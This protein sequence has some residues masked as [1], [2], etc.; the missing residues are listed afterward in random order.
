MAE[1]MKNENDEIDEI[2]FKAEL[3]KALAD[4][5]A[6]VEKYM[7]LAEYVKMKN[8]DC[9]YAQILSDIAHEEQIHHKHIRAILDDIAK[10]ETSEKWM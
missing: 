4:E 10:K 6:D 7:N 5:A 2:D 1:T 9:G 3:E 8:P